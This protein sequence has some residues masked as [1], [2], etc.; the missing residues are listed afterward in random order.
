MVGRA[1]RKPIFPAA[2]A[3]SPHITFE[4]NAV[5]RADME[6]RQPDVLLPG[7]RNSINLFFYNHLLSYV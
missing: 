2:A 3:A 4:K 5:L 7:L 1:G 6:L